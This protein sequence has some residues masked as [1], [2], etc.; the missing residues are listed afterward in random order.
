MDEA[1]FVALYL[2][3]GR[4]GKGLI[5]KIFVLPTKFHS[6]HVNKLG[7]QDVEYYFVKS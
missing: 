1:K 6:K 4:V 7:G 5:K 3:F 2:L